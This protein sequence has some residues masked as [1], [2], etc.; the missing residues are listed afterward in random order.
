MSSVLIID[1]SRDCA[2]LAHKLLERAGHGVTVTEGA[3]AGLKAMRETKAD[4]VLLNLELP[5]AEPSDYVRALRQQAPL[6][7]VAVIG[8][9]AFPHEAA[10]LLAMEVGCDGVI[11]KPIDTRM[12]ASQIEAY[13]RTARYRLQ[14]N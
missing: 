1:H 13:L 14:L 12:F 7:D 5:A 9:L 4:L 3:S 2:R 6:K 11:V 10:E 8:Y